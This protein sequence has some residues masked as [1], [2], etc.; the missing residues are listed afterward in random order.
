M[1]SARSKRFAAT[2][3][4]S[5]SGGAHQQQQSPQQSSKIALQGQVT[6][7]QEL[8]PQ[9][10]AIGSKSEPGTIEASVTKCRPSLLKWQ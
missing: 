6:I 10:I 3:A 2:E 9:P 5:Q 1:E 8:L 7:A 4:E